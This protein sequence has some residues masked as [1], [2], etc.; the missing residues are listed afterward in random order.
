[1]TVLGAGVSLFLIDC[2]W[3]KFFSCFSF[4]SLSSKIGYKDAN[5]GGLLRN[6]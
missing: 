6:T 4:P 1:M 3:S 5:V 2:S